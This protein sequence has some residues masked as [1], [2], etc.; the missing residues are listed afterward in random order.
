MTGHAGHTLASVL[1]ANGVGLVECS[2]KYYRLRGVL[3]AGPYEP[4]ALVELQTVAQRELNTKATTIELYEWLTAK[5]QNRWPS[6]HHDVGAV[7]GALTPLFVAGFYYKT[8]MLPP[9]T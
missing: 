8:F 9:K 4:N 2:F 1:L 5:S 7:N 3:T 6:L